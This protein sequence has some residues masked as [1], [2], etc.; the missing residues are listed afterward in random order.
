MNERDWHQWHDEYNDP[1]TWQFRR[2][3]I[4]QE[5]VHSTLDLVPP[6]PLTIVDI[7]AGQGRNLLPVLTAHPRRQDVRALLVEADPRNADAARRSAAHLPGVEVVTGDAALTDRYLEYA[8]ADLVLLCGVFPHIVMD[9]KARL[10]KF[11]RALTKRRGAVMWTVH[12]PELAAD[13]AGMF[14]IRQFDPIFMTDPSVQ[15]AVCL[16]RHRAEPLSLTLGR[17]M[18]TFVGLENLPAH[19]R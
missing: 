12:R 14:T 11:S 17:R 3:A 4:I 19:E 1:A 5:M 8:P 10:V 15:H 13:I 9:D 7:C 16:M 6:G 2:L 18:F